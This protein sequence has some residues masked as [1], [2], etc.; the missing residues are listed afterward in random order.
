MKQITYWWFFIMI[1]F[2]ISAYLHSKD[3]IRE[4]NKGDISYEPNGI[5]PTKNVLGAP[6]LTALHISIHISMVTGIV[7]SKPY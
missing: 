6:R 1:T 7:F 4:G 3:L 2:L 5:S